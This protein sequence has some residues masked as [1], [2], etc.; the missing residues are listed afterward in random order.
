M[1]PNVET[2]YIK[3]T[4][5]DRF[6]KILTTESPLSFTGLSDQETRYSQ[7]GG[8]LKVLGSGTIFTSNNSIPFEEGMEIQIDDDWYLITRKFKAKVMGEFHHW[9]LIYG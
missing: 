5:K 4:S 8:D 9:E 1:I 2:F 3:Q 7:S 6:G